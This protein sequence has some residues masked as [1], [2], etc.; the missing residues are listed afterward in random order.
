[1]LARREIQARKCYV[2]DIWE[3]AR[4]VVQVDCETVLFNSYDLRTGKLC[5]RPRRQCS[6][7]EIIHWANRE[8]TPAEMSRL[9]RDEMEALFRAQ[10]PGPAQADDRAGTPAAQLQA[11][12]RRSNLRS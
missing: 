2:N 9:R 6:R 11:E 3:R 4:E 7:N 12:A 10:D 1:M 8:A 5:G